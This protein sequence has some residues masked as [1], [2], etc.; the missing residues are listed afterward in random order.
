MGNFPLVAAVHA[1]DAQVQA[2]GGVDTD[3]DGSDAQVEPWPCTRLADLVNSTRFQSRLEFFAR[4]SDIASTSCR[5]LRTGLEMQF[6]FS[7]SLVCL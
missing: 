2:A 4:N 6:G 7:P 1:F 3:T 5:Q